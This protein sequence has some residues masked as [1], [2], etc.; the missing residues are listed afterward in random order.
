MQK[1]TH[2]CQITAAYLMHQSETGNDSHQGKQDAQDC[3]CCLP[4][5]SSKND[6][7]LFLLAPEELE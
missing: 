2:N 5:F 4:T 3:H 1:R 7:F 6:K